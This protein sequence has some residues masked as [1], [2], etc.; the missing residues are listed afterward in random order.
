MSTY[1]AIKMNRL[2]IYI[3]LFKFYMT[4]TWSK[5]K[6]PDLFNK[7]LFTLKNTLRNDDAKTGGK[8][9]PNYFLLIIFILSFEYNQQ[10]QKTWRKKGAI[11]DYKELCL[12]N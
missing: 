5:S 6:L 9:I 7:K 10:Q 3:I 1:T 12:M 2:E 8:W 4:K 11:T